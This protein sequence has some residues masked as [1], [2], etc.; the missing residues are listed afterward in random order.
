MGDIRAVDDV[1]FAV[2]ARETLG[3]VGEPGSGKTTVARCL[4]RLV[5]PTSGNIRLAVDGAS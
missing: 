2:A 1:S 3:I 5:E 4:M